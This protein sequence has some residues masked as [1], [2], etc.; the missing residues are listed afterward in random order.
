MT[1]T[2]D[3]LIINGVMTATA[4][5][6]TQAVDVSNWRRGSFQAIWTGTPTGLFTV[7]VSDVVAPD[8]LT[9]FTNLGITSVDPA[10]TDDSTIFTFDGFPW[11]WMYL[12]YENVSGAGVL[13]VHFYAKNE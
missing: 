2:H 12:R 11:H 5:L 10:G 13:N 9:Q 6:S 1:K 7:W 3:H 8:A 4:K